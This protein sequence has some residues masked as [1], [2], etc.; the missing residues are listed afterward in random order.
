MKTM[1]LAVAV[2]AFALS[3]CAA[4]PEAMAEA[5]PA[6]EAARADTAAE[7]IP[8]SAMSFLFGEWVGTAKGTDANQQPYEVIQ[9][10][11]VGPLLDGKITLIE[12]RGY[13]ASGATLFN[14]FAVVS[15]NA[16]T[17]ALEFRSYSGDYAGT[18]PF[19]LT[20]N[21]FKWSLP[22]GPAA[23]MVYTAVVAGDSWEQ[24]GEYVPDGGAPVKVF[25]MSL[26]RTGPSDWP[27]S[28]RVVP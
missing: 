18:Y 17:G 13:D 2:L 8:D 28:G 1:V 6:S 25:E 3:G 9:T 5:A 20:A 10:E 26:K 27:A 14:A 21:G 11:R 15:K 16:Q 22:A 4:V 7:P 19:E 24:I 23:R 12:G